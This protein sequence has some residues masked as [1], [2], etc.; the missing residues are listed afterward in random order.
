MLDGLC[1]PDR[2]VACLCVSPCI[3]YVGL[4]AYVVVAMFCGCVAYV[5]AFWHPP[6][7]W[8]QV[9]ALDNI[10]NQGQACAGTHDK[11]KAAEKQQQTE[12][13]NTPGQRN[14]AT[15]H[16][17]QQTSANSIMN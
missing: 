17:A 13:A 7:A 2:F 14:R 4:C 1:G 10:Q 11:V 3:H 16:K 15:K 5:S 8:F 6:D 9:S 12:L